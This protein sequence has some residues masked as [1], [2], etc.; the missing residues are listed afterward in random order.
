MNRTSFHFHRMSDLI[1]AQTTGGTNPPL[2]VLEQVCRESPRRVDRGAAHDETGSHDLM[3]ALQKRPLQLTGG[4]HNRFS[5]DAMDQNK[6]AR[7]P[8]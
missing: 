3:A 2:S 5:Q 4:Q 1:C 6:D 8:C 7:D